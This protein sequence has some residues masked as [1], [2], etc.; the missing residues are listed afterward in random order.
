M[1]NNI[2]KNKKNTAT[3]II[4]EPLQKYVPS[5]KITIIIVIILIVA[6]IYSFRISIIGLVNTVFNKNSSLPIPTLT[7]PIKQQEFKPLSIDVDTDGDSLTDWQ[8]TLLG[9]DPKTV[10][11]KSTVPDSVRQLV[12]ISS[13]NLVTVEDKLAL[14]VYERLKTE[15]KGSNM[16]EAFQ[17]AT[18]KEILDLANSID[19]QFTTYSLDDLEIID[20]TPESRDTYKNNIISFKKNLYVNEKTAKDIYEGILGD[21]KTIGISTAQ[22]SLTQSVSKLLAMPVPMKLADIHLILVNALAHSNDALIRRSN[23]GSQDSIIYASL[24]VFQKNANLAQEMLD[25]ILKL[26]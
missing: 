8:E 21:T 24:L 14:R 9:T 12:D 4:P 15:P 18:T 5:K 7:T 10:T 26:L 2:S 25:V 23:T 20:D 16:V 22:V 1:E 13:K 6:I 11:P 3:H 17:A 19:K